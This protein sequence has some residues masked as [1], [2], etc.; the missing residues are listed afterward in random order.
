MSPKYRIIQR[1]DTCLGVDYFYIERQDYPDSSWIP[2][3]QPYSRFRTLEAA[4][5]EVKTIKLTSK[6][7]YDKETNEI[8]Y[9]S[10]DDWFNETLGFSYRSEWI[11]G[12]VV[13]S[14]PDSLKYW[15]NEAFNIGRKLGQSEQ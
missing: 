6:Y 10:F 4:Q 9:S 15:L 12:D 14:N 13:S 1:L 11:D 3:T 8:P 2:I 5:E 7:Y